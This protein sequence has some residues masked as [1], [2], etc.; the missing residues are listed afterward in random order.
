MDFHYS[1]KTQRLQAQL[2]NFMDDHVMPRLARWNDEV[3]AGT[4]PVSFMDDLKA[5]AREEGLWN[6]FLPHL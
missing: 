3:H 1:E 6:M 4:Y 2:T 5:L